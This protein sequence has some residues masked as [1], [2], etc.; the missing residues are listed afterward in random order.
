MNG[1]SLSS[2]YVMSSIKVPCDL[3]FPL[4][5]KVHF[6]AR[7]ISNN[8]GSVYKATGGSQNGGEVMERIEGFLE[9]LVDNRIL[10][11]YL[12]YLGITLLSPATLVP[13]AL[14]MGKT[15]FEE[16]VK[17][18]KKNDT[19]IQQGGEG[20]LDIRVPIVDDKIVGTSLK[21]A[22][23]TAL[24][25]SPYTLVPLGVL[26]Y[27]YD[28]YLKEM[29]LPNLVGGG[30]ATVLPM[31][32]FGR[33][34]CS[35]GGNLLN[36]NLDTPQLRSQVFSNGPST[37]SSNDIVRPYNGGRKRKQIK[38]GG[39]NW[40]AGRCDQSNLTTSDVGNTFQNHVS[41]SSSNDIVRPYAG[42]SKKRTIKNGGYNWDSGRSDQSNL[43]TSD[44]G[45]TFQ[46]HTAQASSNDI[47][48]PFAGGNKK[49]SIKKGGYNWNAGRCDQSNLTTTDVGNTFQNHVSQ[50]SSNDI[51]R[52]FAGGSKR[53]NIKKGGSRSILAS[54]VPPNFLQQTTALLTGQDIGFP[55]GNDYLNNE[56][57]VSQ[58]GIQS[59]LHYQAPYHQQLET[60]I[61]PTNANSC[62][63][64]SNCPGTP[65]SMAGGAGSDWVGTLYSAGPSNNSNM[66]DQQFQMFNK[67]QPNPS[68]N[69]H[70]GGLNERVSNFYN[71]NNYRNTL[72]YT[73]LY[74]ES[75][76]S[77]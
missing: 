7:D 20:F 54:E 16:V 36:N 35:V 3:Q 2:D 26:M 73:P 4:T 37:Q 24:T 56:M 8:Y 34:S 32:Y 42:G 72:E 10:D 69:S 57:Q 44:V 70:T 12:K 30:I 9:K 31:E 23:I 64:T 65:L 58:G 61:M 19:I 76:C 63:A 28:Q 60:I 53:C 39:F 40:N 6:S 5:E 38:K 18:M 52:P 15:T 62:A 68:M 43:T 55:R 25:I 21:L 14:I 33:K 67:S 46:N 77:K 59:Q 75:S 17:N 29:N 50:A 45:N 49:R 48:R 74:A 41:Q 11:L 47:V 51:V 66:S 27:I 13:I 1:G 22:G 71:Y